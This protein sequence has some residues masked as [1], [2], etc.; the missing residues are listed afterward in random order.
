M[1]T[2]YRLSDAFVLIL[3][4]ATIFSSCGISKQK[5]SDQIAKSNVSHPEW[6]VNA[7]IYEVNVRQYTPEGTFNAFAEHL[8]R[9]QKMGVDILWF[10]PVSPIGVKERK[11]TLGSYYSVK[12]YTAINPEFGNDGRF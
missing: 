9:L 12:D 11:G 8:P 7:N 4:A 1:K 2:F 3:L 10:M 6:S 5:E